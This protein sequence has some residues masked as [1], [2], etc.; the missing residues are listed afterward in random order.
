MNTASAFRP[1]PVLTLLAACCVLGPGF[2]PIAWAQSNPARQENLELSQ[3]PLAFRHAVELAR[4]G[5]GRPLPFEELMGLVRQG[6]PEQEIL[7]KLR[8]SSP[9]PSLTADRIRQL[10]EA[11][12]PAAVLAWLE[13]P[14]ATFRLVEVRASRGY[15]FNFPQPD[16]KP[17]FEEKE[18]VYK[19][20][21]QTIETGGSR[22]WYDERL[23]LRVEA[24]ESI[25]DGQSV[26]L[27]S[28]VRTD[29]D[30]RL[31]EPSTS[32][33]YYVA[34]VF[35]YQKQESQAKSGTPESPVHSGKY[36]LETESEITVPVIAGDATFGG[37][38][39]TRTFYVRAES[40]VAGSQAMLDVWF[41]YERAPEPLPA[42]PEA[43]VTEP[44]VASGAVA[45]NPGAPEP[46]G[47]ILRSPHVK[48]ARGATVLVPVELIN[49]RDVANLDFAMAFRPEIASAHKT[50]E[51]GSLVAEIFQSNLVNP[52][53]FK[54]NFAQ[55][56]PVNGSGTVAGFRFTATG[57]AA[58]RTP[59][60]LSV[61]TIN[62]GDGNP[63]PLTTI[64]GSISIY[65][66]NNPNDP[67]HPDFNRGTA[68]ARPSQP[69]CSGT[70]Q[71]TVNDAQCCLKM[72]VELIPRGMHMDLDTSGDVDSRDAVIV[73]RNVRQSLIQRAQ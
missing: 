32:L 35:K 61:H 6:A 33:P 11:G 43:A 3:I 12:A 73:L 31:K 37:D 2:T 49:A 62:D 20:N 57:P 60:G 70:G 64:D 9:R 65:D 19:A 26:R 58:S 67:N 24:P 71:Q 30:F 48:V 21:P 68:N 39:F 53:Q 5:T 8:D 22:S 51:K 44:G 18:S 41:K 29:W 36:H 25:E 13:N 38:Q 17:L 46:T 59:L 10:R 27:R 1:F 45:G 23:V 34:T 28:T 72:W 54:F 69:T 55:L 63:L 14:P 40:G 4:A 52:G 16:D 7:Q 66:P 47:M 56:K 42:A 15:G 50:A